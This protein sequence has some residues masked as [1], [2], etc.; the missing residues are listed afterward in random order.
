[1]TVAKTKIPAHPA[2][3]ELSDYLDHRL[4][5]KAK[6]RVEL[7]VASC[8][9]CLASLV[10]AYE[11]VKM[12]RKETGANKRK[13]NFMKRLNIYLILAVISFLLSF[14]VPRYFAQFLVATTLLGIKW[15]S[16]A[17]ST[18]MLVM[19]YDAWKRGGEKEASRILSTIES[20]Q[21]NRF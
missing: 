21:K 2:E 16:D 14:A 6:E 3:R 12:F 20:G 13:G 18:K 8:P 15:I 11:S 19:I 1:M 10:S 17:K 7:H 5:G 4:G 9:E